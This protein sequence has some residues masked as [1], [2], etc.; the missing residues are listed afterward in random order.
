LALPLAAH[1]EPTKTIDHA[2]IL[3][4]DVVSAAPEGL[5]ELD[6]GPAP[7][8]GGSRLLTKPDLERELRGRG[9]DV[10][11]LAIPAAVRVVG[12]A[13]RI[14]PEKMAALASPYIEKELP[15]GVTLTSVR[16]SYEVVVPPGAEVKSV[17]LPKIM[18]QKGSQRSTATIEL[19]CEGTPVAKVPVA[20]VLEVSEQ[21]ARPD[22]ARQSRLNLSLER[23]PVK[24]STVGQLLADANVGDN[25]R[26][27]VVATGR[28]V[29]A[30]ILSRDEARL[31]EA[32]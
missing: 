3:L 2:R 11:K 24:V 10:A 4:G 29:E 31:V 14:A 7:P 12:A 22:V 23:G 19:A 26:M 32:P 1:A 15:P 27:L 17:Q 28:V 13:H 21:A 5:A 16:A 8:P 9:V 25:V 6:L 20:V 18:R 30:R